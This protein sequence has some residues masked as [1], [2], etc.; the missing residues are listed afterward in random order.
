MDT[1]KPRVFS[2]REIAIYGAIL[3][4]L[5]LFSATQ[6]A[7][8]SSYAGR[9]VNWLFVYGTSVLGWLTCGVGTPLYL[10]LI[11]RHPLERSNL[12]T[13]IPLYLAVIGA[14]VVLKFA[15]W[16]PIENM[17]F[18]TKLTFAQSIVPNAFGVYV[19]QMYFVVLLY[20]VELYRAARKR[21]LRSS[22]LEAELSQA[23]LQALR[24]QLNP[25]FLFNTLNSVSALM[26]SDVDAADEM[27]ARLSDMLRLTLEADS[28]QEVRLQSELEL[29]ARYLEIMRVRFGERL[30]T[31]VDVKESLLDERVPSFLLQPLVENVVRHGIDESS[32]MTNIRITGSADEQTL[33]LRIAD[34]GRGLPENGQIHEGIGLRNTRRRL[35][36][37]YGSAG[38]LEVQNRN[39]GGTEVLIRIP[40]R[41]EYGPLQGAAAT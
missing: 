20:A 36:R 39:G 27:L 19:E 33:M 15:L 6:E 22:Q 8:A 16:V 41:S 30:S 4:L 37:L 3:I 10:W 14:C 17:L 13:T 32:S 40:R 5:G 24:S 26:R 34:D 18:H 25:H 28:G 35:E 23:Q 38:T 31:H 29:I 7:V 1:S 2:W 21:E 9:S 11:R 12:A